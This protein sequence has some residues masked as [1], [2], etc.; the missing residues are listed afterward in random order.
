VSRS[1]PNEALRRAID[2][3][4]LTRPALADRLR[5]DQ[6]TLERWISTGRLPHPRNR[7][8]AAAAL[9]VPEWSLWHVPP[10]QPRPAPEPLVRIEAERRQYEQ[11]LWRLAEHSTVHTRVPSRTIDYEIGATPD[12]DLTTDTWEI[13][14][15]DGGRGILWWLFA[16]GAS[17]ELV[18][19]K[20][21]ARQL[22]RLEAHEL[23]GE[24]QVRELPVLH[25]DHRDGK[26]WAIVIFDR[27]LGRRTLRVRWSWSGIW[28]MLRATRYDRSALDLRELATVHWGTIDVAFRFPGCFR[29]PDV[30]TA[31]TVPSIVR[32]VTGDDQ[33]RTVFTFRLDYPIRQLYIWDMEVRGFDPL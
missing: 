12:E 23:A 8:A 17:G 29:E 33:D 25:L 7:A 22:E 4:G 15:L 5:V 11:A 3:S 27:E 26:S 28:N 13:E 18:P 24:D 1:V 20:S 14:A 21:T 32:D 6:K 19:P 31:P 9:G 10:A 2:V 16:V 30:R